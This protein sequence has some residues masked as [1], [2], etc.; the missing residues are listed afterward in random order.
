MNE[1]GGEIR[2]C[3]DQVT[4]FQV[5]FLSFHIFIPGARCVNRDHA[6]QWYTR[7]FIELLRSISFLLHYNIKQRFFFIA[8]KGLLILVHCVGICM[9]CRYERLFL[10][11]HH[12]GCPRLYFLP[13]RCTVHHDCGSHCQL[14]LLLHCVGNLSLADSRLLL[15]LV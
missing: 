9:F 10:P 11:I 6:L 2:M 3:I 8:V 5:S 7:K 1:R 13:Q 14:S 15:C 12:S 4:S